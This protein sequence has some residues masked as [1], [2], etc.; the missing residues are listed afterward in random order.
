ML[1]MLAPGTPILY[2]LKTKYKK[3]LKA[4]TRRGKKVRI[5]EIFWL[6]FFIINVIFQ[7]I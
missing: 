2:T 4:K 5:K 1:Y 6:V 3:K 7:I